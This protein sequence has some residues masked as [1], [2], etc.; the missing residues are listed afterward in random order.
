[1]NS[2]QLQGCSF[3]RDQYIQILQMLKKNRRVGYKGEDASHTHKAQANTAG[4]ALLV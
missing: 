4:K 1:M 3:T 2:S